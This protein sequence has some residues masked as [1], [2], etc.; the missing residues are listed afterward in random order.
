M[1][2]LPKMSYGYETLEPY[3]DAR[4]MDVHYNGHHAGYVKNLNAVVERYPELAKKSLVW[5]L[6][7]L[8]QFSEDIR[9]VVQNNG[10]GHYNHTFWW[11]QLKKNDGALPRGLLMEYIERDYHTE[12]RQSYNERSP[13]VSRSRCMGACVLSEVPKQEG[14]VH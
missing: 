12:P 3:I 5:L 4:T 11:P 9:V 14:F 7:N 6:Q 13:T 2:K 10:G 1:F 8:N